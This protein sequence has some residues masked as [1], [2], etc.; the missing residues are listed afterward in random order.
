MKEKK[1]KSGSF[2][3]SQPLIDDKRFDKKI[4]LI[5]EHNKQGTLGFI[6]NKITKIKI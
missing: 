5:T 3:I 6:I 4:I 1:I 2:I